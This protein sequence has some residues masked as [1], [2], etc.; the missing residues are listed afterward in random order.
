[1][2]EQEAV[3]LAIKRNKHKSKHLSDKRWSPIHNSVK[4]WHVA[5]VDNHTTV[6]H[7]QRE[8][9]RQAVLEGDPDQLREA[10]GKLLSARCA[11]TIEEFENK[12]PDSPLIGK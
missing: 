3:D 4:G 11:A 10:A 6:I 2:T 7:T 9:A 5:L 8:V 1:M 12:Y